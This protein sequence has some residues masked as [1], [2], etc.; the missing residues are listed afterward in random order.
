VSDVRWLVRTPNY[1][2]VVAPAR[3]QQ[4]AE[5]LVTLFRTRMRQHRSRVAWEY[6]THI[7]GM[8][9]SYRRIGP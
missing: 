1:P 3:N 7:P 5:E 4:H 2:N 8:I 9:N 6:G